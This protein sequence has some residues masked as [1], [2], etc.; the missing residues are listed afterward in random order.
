MVKRQFQIFDKAP[1]YSQATQIDIVYAAM[2]LHNF[3]KSHPGNE[4][5]IYYT[6]INISDD[7]G[8]DGG[9]LNMQSS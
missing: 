4:E 2:G 7:A 3:I 1:G 6:P 8:N 9:I 5:D